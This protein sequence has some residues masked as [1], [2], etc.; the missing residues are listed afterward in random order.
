[1]LKL[2]LGII[3]IVFHI[4][5][6]RN[7]WGSKLGF[8]VLLFHSVEQADSL[9]TELCVLGLPVNVYILMRRCQ[10]ISLRRD[11]KDIKH[12]ENNWGK[13]IV[14]IK[15]L[16]FEHA[17]S[18]KANHRFQLLIICAKHFAIVVIFEMFG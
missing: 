13:I 11:H 18:G 1:M 5:T 2:Y 16:R 7:W 6:S 9:P 12:V 4:P 17:N 15:D 8:I 3:L 10:S 14:L